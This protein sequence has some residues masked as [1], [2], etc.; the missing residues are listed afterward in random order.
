MRFLISIFTICLFISASGQMRVGAER[1]EIY[2]PLLRN[3]RVGLVAN[4]TSTVGQVHLV[5]T[6]KQSGIKW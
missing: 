2:F 1:T 4:P 6:L 3:K 5:D